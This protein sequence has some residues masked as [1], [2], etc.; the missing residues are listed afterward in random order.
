MVEK[1]APVPTA[2][3]PKNSEMKI[4]EYRAL[5]VDTVRY[6]GDGVAAIVAIDDY[7]ARDAMAAI[8]VQYEQL[9]VVTK[10]LDSIE[11]GAPQL[12]EN[13]PNNIAFH[14]N[15]S[16]GDVDKAFEEADL[17][18]SQRIYNQRL[19]PNPIETRGAVAQYDPGS[20]ELTLWC[21]TQNPHVH[22]MLMS[23]V[24]G[25]PE[26]LIRVIAPDVGG[27]FGAKI[28]FYSGEMLATVIAKDLQSAVRWFEDRTEN[29][30]ATTHGRD[31]VD[32]VE[33]AAASD[34]RI[35]G[36]RVKAYANMGAYLSTAAPGVPTWLF[37]V[38]LGG[39]Y[40]IKNIVSDV[41]GVLTNTM[42]TDAYR[43]AGRPEATFIIE[44][45]MDM[46]AAKLNLDPV[47]VRRKNFI[48]PDQF[49]YPIASGAISYDSGEYEKTLDRALEMVDYASLK[50]ERDQARAEGRMFGIG[51][52]TYVEVCGLAPSAAAGAM[53][54][55]GGL[56]ESG[57]VRVHPTG[58]VSVFTGSSTHGQ[59]HET[60]FAQLVNDELGVP[61]DDIEVIH[62][63]TNRIAFGW[64]TYGSRS[65]AVGGSALVHASR[66]V[67]DKM[68]KIGAHMLEVSPE[69]VIF[70]QGDVHVQG[71]PDQV[72]RFGEIV[73]AA[74]TAWSLPE[75]VTPG[76]D[77]THFFDPVS[78]TYPFGAHVC[79]VEIDQ[80]TGETK[81]RRYVAVDD[82]GNVVN[83]MIV[84]GQVHGGIAQGL[85]Q[86]VF[87]NAVYDEN[88]QLLTG[89]MMDYAIPKASFLPYYELDR[90]VTPCPYNP[91]GLKGAG[92]TGTIAS[93]PAVMNAIV[94]ALSPYGVEHLD[95]P[96]SPQRIWQE[97]QERKGS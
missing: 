20:R 43:G 90:T 18:F 13:V 28:P 47:D 75:G 95:M 55:G 11:D 6:V 57:T 7:A 67:R 44:R 8:D 4:P 84:D 17:T 23:M 86:A 69:E 53:G 87:E 88:G 54:W 34:G 58:K 49:P 38:M 85:A 19:I 79:V 36:L 41:Y 78:N 96:A 2:W 76:L 14:F 97:L 30:V 21:T 66:K 60:T 29:Y 5:A 94:D 71:A 45:V 51:F 80:A 92:E 82:V 25:I 91:M 65:T 62:G 22:R 12:Y 10:Q 37:S 27:G 81:F 72:K 3:Q 77:E 46:V 64:G 48:H 89:T 93:T 15:L 83:P 68:I 70:D 16:G 50:R 39:A 40:D 61:L 31:H 63:D 9:P 35:L 33:V 59:G 73:L 56:Y 52:S 26:T 74:Y 24:T 32:D 42:A 1:L